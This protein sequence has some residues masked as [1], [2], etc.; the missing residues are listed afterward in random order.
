MF[1]IHFIKTSSLNEELYHFLLDMGYTS[2]DLKF[3]LELGKIL[4]EGKG[5]SKE[6]VWE[7]YYTPELKQM[8]RKKERLIFTMFPEFDV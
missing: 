6:Q 2:E 7:Q 5:R 8:V 1:N 3:I 4:P